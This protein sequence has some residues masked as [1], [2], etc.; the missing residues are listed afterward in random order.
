M[1]SKN[2]SKGKDVMGENARDEEM[3][4]SLETAFSRRWNLADKEVVINLEEIKDA[5]EERWTRTLIGK[6]HTKR[7]FDEEDI[8]RE[9]I[10]N[11]NFKN[12]F[13]FSLVADGICTITFKKEID[14]LFVL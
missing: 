8:K 9:L 7:W 13:D 3:I 12:K 1:A 6:L 5:D 4:E 14:Y 10:K 11:W 2:L